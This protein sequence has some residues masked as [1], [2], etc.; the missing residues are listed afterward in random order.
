MQHYAAAPQS[1]RGLLWKSSGMRK[2]R[3]PVAPAASPTQR[4]WAGAGMSVLAI[5]RQGCFRGREAC[6]D[7][8]E[9]REAEAGSQG[10]E[11]AV[12]AVPSTPL[13]F[14]E[15]EMTRIR[16][17]RWTRSEDQTVGPTFH[18]AD[19]LSQLGLYEAETTRSHQV[20]WRRFGGQEEE[21][22]LHRRVP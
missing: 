7:C 12:H 21:P 17:M 8:S 19:L 18:H 13:G 10:V 3:D 5:L 2:H 16:Q 4:A 14:Y 11:P 20:R 9:I 22:A 15:S 1:R 6:L